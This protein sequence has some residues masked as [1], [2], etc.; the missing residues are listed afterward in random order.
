MK[1][2]S[3]LALGLGLLMALAA[4]AVYAFAPADATTGWWGGTLDAIGAVN[5]LV[6]AGLAIVIALGV[7][8]AGGR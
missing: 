3:T 8:I 5:E 4:V 6:W 1:V 7:A 2:D